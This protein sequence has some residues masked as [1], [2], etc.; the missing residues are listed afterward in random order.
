MEHNSRTKDKLI[1]EGRLRLWSTDLS[2]GRD[3]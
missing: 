1:K 2:R 3:S